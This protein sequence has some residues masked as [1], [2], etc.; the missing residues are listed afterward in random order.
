MKAINPGFGL[1]Q[2]LSLAT[3][4]TVVHPKAYPASNGPPIFPATVGG[5]VIGN[6]GAFWR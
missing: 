6:A 4:P 2:G 3:S 5:A 1:N